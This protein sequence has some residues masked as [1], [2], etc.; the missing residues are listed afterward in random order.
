MNIKVLYED[1]HL[2]AVYKPA[3]ILVQGDE[4]GDKCLMDEVK[5]YLIE[6]YQKPG[7]VF[8]GLIHRLD[9][10]VSGIILFAK[11]S[12]GASRLSEQFRAHKVKKIYY[13]LVEGKP[14]MDSGTLIHYLKKDEQKIQRDARRNFKRE[15]LEQRNIEQGNVVHYYLSFIKFDSVNERWLAQAKTIAKYGSLF[16]LAELE[17][18]IQKANEFIAKNPPYFSP[19]KWNRILTECTIFNPDGN[20]LRLDR[21]MIN[22]REKLIKILDYKTGEEYNEAQ[23]NEYAG[24]VRELSLVKE[25]G[26]TIEAK[27]VEVAL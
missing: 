9:R 2:I 13:A 6:K 12:K 18:I 23:I 22:E 11:T 25:K 1:N 3:G 5:K 4:T 7:N 15:Y 24:A 14:F 26:F 27:F 16:K 10:P 8:L 19:E 17:K 20:E 21:L